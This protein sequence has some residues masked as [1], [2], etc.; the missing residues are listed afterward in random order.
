MEVPCTCCWFCECVVH[1]WFSKVVHNFP[2]TNFDSRD[3][4]LQAYDYEMVVLNI[5][6]NLPANRIAANAPDFL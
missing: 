6:H 4:K 2:A 1:L 5:H 3:L